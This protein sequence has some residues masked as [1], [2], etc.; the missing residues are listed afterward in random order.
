MTS[1]PGLETIAIHILRNI[2]QSNS[3]RQ[4]NLVNWLNITKEI[5]LF[6]N[7]AKKEAGRLVPD[8]F[9]F[10]KSLLWGKSKW[11]PVLI[12]L[13]LPYNKTKPYKTFI[14]PEICSILNFQK[15]VWD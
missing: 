5:F 11:S 3:T 14:D 7:Y 6:K 12:A 10:W 13:S 9:I 2:S 1:Q 15:T 4:W 8:L